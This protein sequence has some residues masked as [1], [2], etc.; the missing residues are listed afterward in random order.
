MEILSL[1][2]NL[3]A[4]IAGFIAAHGNLIYLLLFAIVFLEI[5]IFPLFFLPGNPLIFIAGSFCKLGSLHSGLAIITLATA[6]IMGNII[7][8]QLGR[9][10]GTKINSGQSHWINQNAL[11]KTR[12]FY[13][14]Y[15]Q[16]TLMISP[17]IAV[18]RTFAPLLAGVGEMQYRKYVFAS[19]I[20]A[21]LWVV[22]LVLTGYFFSSIPF[23]RQHMASIVLAGL[24]VGLGFVIYGFVKSR[25]K[26]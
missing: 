12:N 25:V 10:F 5:G 20:G 23:I 16:A 1:L 26:K 18:V 22:I 7:S 13:A 15:G 14:K 8:Y 9:L 4:Q 21:V 2:S 11:N 19:T 17:F 3:D 24:A 6:A